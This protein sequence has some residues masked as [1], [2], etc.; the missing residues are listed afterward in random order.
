MA[1]AKAPAAAAPARRPAPAAAALAEPAAP[2]EADT[3]P[4]IHDGPSDSTAA[5]GATLQHIV[6]QL[7]ILT[8][9]VALLEERL[10]MNEDRMKR[11]EDSV[12]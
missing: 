5:L 11:I 10:T 4:V 2:V 1:K 6:G 3:V 12:A 8:Q 7:D 9:T